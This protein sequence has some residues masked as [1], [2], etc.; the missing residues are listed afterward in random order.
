MSKH[1]VHNHGPEDGPGLA[2][3]ERLIGDCELARLRAENQRLREALEH[4]DSEL[5]LFMD[6]EA[7]CDHSVNICWC[8][9]NRMR[10]QMRT[11]LK[12]DNA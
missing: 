6:A 11:A 2:C 1:M 9:Y 4:A 7:V 3:P 5:R 10:E 8:T 12:G